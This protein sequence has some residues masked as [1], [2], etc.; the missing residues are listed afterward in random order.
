MD[1]SDEDIVEPDF[2]EQS[3]TCLTPIKIIYYFIQVLLLVIGIGVLYYCASLRVNLRAVGDPD[4][5]LNQILDFGISI[6]VLAIIY[7][8][9]G[10]VSVGLKSR[11]SGT[12]Y[13]VMVMLAIFASLGGIWWAQE[14]LAM[15]KGTMSEVWDGLNEPSKR[16]LQDLGQCCGYRGPTDRSVS[17]CT[18]VS[19]MPGCFP[20]DAPSPILEWLRG[21]LLFGLSSMFFLGSILCLLNIF[22][23]FIHNPH[24]P[25]K[26]RIF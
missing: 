9:L 4:R 26:Q 13:I 5:L 8:T 10:I 19:R 22:I 11:T 2:R 1:S 20:K 15:L 3:D 14:K 24:S 12:I 7:A 21:A 16:Y 18:P 6:G 17:P 23:L 25:G